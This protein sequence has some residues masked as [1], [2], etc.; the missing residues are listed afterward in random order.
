MKRQ[1]PPIYV[2]LDVWNVI[3]SYTD[4]LAINTLLGIANDSR[5]ATIDHYRN[6]K[7]FR[8]TIQTIFVS[9][10]SH[11]VLSTGTTMVFYAF[12]ATRYTVYYLRP[13]ISLLYA[14]TD[15]KIPTPI[16]PYEYLYWACCN[17]HE[18]NYRIL[19]LLMQD[20][21]LDVSAYNNYA[22]YKACTIDSRYASAQLVKQ[23][24]TSPTI[25]PKL[26][27]TRIPLAMRLLDR[28]DPIF[29]SQIV[30]PSPT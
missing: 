26:H 20:E 28:C 7:E 12:N 1:R 21:R 13:F 10:N 5:I 3:V 17:P 24:L 18:Y 29:F 14:F 27:H 4:V 15:S 19:A 30:V 2:P 8:K 11:Y 22:L 16:D 25:D 6:P 23:L 9:I